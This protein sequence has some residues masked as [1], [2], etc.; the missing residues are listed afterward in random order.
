MFEHRL[1]MERKLNRYLLPEEVVDHKDGL[2]LHN[3]PDNLRH[4]ATN[5]EHLQET[6]A[7]CV[8]LWSEAGKK[9]IL[10]RFDPPAGRT[11]VDT[12]RRRKVSGAGRLHQILLAALSLGRDS[13]FLSGTTHHTKKAGIDMTSRST[14]ERAL[15]DL[16]RRWREDLTQ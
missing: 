9:N 16:L 2:H 14:I 11:L 4:F 13:P 15:A 6:L 5:A 7:G 1:V 10:E 8:P 12:Y 3:A